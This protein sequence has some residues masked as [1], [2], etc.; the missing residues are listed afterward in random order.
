LKALLL[1]RVDL[2]DVVGCFGFGPR[3]TDA[4][5][6]SWGVDSFFLEGALE[7]P[8]GRDQRGIEEPAQFDSDTAR[9]PGGVPPLELASA[10]QDLRGMPSSG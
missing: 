4:L 2:P 6:T 7:R 3:G 10:A 1:D 9:S 5:R 8:N